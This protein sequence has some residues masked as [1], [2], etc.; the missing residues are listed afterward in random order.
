MRWT[1]PS[2]GT[3]RRSGTRSTGTSRRLNRNGGTSGRPA[4]FMIEHETYHAGEINHIRLLIQ[5]NDA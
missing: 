3:A 1:V 4:A 5:G 2:M